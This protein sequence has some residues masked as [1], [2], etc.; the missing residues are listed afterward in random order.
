MIIVRV[1]ASPLKLAEGHSLKIVNYS[2][3]LY[4]KYDSINSTF[5]HDW[6]RRFEGRLASA[7]TLGFHSNLNVFICR[8]QQDF[9]RVMYDYFSKFT[10]VR[11]CPAFGT[12]FDRAHNA[13]ALFYNLRNENILNHKYLCIMHLFQVKNNC[14]YVLIASICSSLITVKVLETRSQA[15]FNHYVA[16]LLLRTRS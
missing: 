2:K 11:I 15:T 10:F 13:N 16:R 9:C 4:L 14:N 12:H 5:A 3:E 8:V 1:R 7:T 6:L